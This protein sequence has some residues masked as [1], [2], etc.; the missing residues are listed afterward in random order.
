MTWVSWSL[1]TEPSLSQ[2]LCT[3]LDLHFRAI[4]SHCWMRKAVPFNTVSAAYTGKR[5]RHEN[6]ALSFHRPE[7]FTLQ[8][9]SFCQGLFSYFI[10][11]Q[12]WLF[13]FSASFPLSSLV[14]LI[15]PT[16]KTRPELTSASVSLPVI[17]DTCSARPLQGKKFLFTPFCRLIA[18]LQIRWLIV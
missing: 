15:C 13:T 12:L 7:L 5:A 8:M 6:C 10:K 18:R 14:W 17:T 11:H 3:D 2:T 4:H 16:L 9:P 1:L